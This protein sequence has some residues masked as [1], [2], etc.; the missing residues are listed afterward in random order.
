MAQNFLITL[1]TT[2]FL[3]QKG[4]DIDI[5]QEQENLSFNLKVFVCK[6]EVPRLKVILNDET[7][8]LDTT[9]EEVDFLTPK[10]SVSEEYISL[11]FKNVTLS[12]KL[13]D[14]GLAFD[15]LDKNSEDELI[16]STWIMYSEIED[17]FQ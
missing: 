16:D 13:D 5:S 17:D 6:I 4:V 7:T 14:E 1:N 3:N 9:V 12:I 11:D 15:L 8:L 2:E 10:W